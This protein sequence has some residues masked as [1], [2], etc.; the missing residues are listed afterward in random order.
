MENLKTN[1]T[2]KNP[3]HIVALQ[4]TFLLFSSMMQAQENPWES[5]SSGTNPWTGETVEAKESS[6]PK[7][8]DTV[9]TTHELKQL[10]SAPLT[11]QR[12]AELRIYASEEYRAPAALGVSILTSSVFSFFALPVNLISSV[13]P[14]PKTERFV[15]NYK[16]AH[17]EA[18]RTEI[19]EIKK[20][21]RNK[22]VKNSA[23]GSLIGIGINLIA[24][25]VIVF[26]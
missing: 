21:V 24:I 19:K 26:N 18:T 11:Y 13:V 1:T 7:S 14:A 17:P 9:L 6:S 12:K 3:L 2:K 15:R 22:R 5:S 8:S 4:I 23:L 25:I 10:P 16:H 20:G